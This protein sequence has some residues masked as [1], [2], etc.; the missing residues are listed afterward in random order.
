VVADDVAAGDLIAAARAAGGRLVRDVRLFDR[1][2]GG[3]VADGKVSLA[4]RLT[5]ADPGRTLTDEEIGGAVKR[6]RK[7]LARDFDAELRE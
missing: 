6:V 7:R 5:I 1:Y 2:A 3:Q 4:L